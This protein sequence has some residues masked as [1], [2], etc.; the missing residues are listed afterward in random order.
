MHGKHKVKAGDVGVQMQ[1]ALG[2]ALLAISRRAA[3]R[4]RKDAALA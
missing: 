3:L 2:A 1:V 4:E